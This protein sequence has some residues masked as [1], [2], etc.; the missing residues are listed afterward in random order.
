MALTP[1]IAQEIETAA[2]ILSNSY[3]TY[4]NNV[5]RFRPHFTTETLPRSGLLAANTVFDLSPLR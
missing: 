5:S 4:L 2:N 3:I 1:T